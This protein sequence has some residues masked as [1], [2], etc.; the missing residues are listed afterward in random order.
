MDPS[1]V[2]DGWEIYDT[3][4]EV[5]GRMLRFVAYRTSDDIQAGIE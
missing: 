1:S 5:D 4:A 2:R 3:D